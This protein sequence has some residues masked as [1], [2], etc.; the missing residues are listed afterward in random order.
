MMASKDAVAPKA[1]QPLQSTRSLSK[2]ESPA[3]MQYRVTGIRSP[4]ARKQSK[5]R[6][7]S[8]I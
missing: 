8:R 1:D 2:G 4:S 6:D 7:A 5:S 3:K